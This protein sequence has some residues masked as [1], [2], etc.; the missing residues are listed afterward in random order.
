MIM[1][2]GKSERDAKVA[3][4]KLKNFL[5]HGHELKASDKE[6]L[7]KIC[8]ALLR[9]QD[10]Y[11]KNEKGRKEEANFQRKIAEHFQVYLLKK[12]GYTNQQIIDLVPIVGEERNISRMISRLR[13]RLDIKEEKGEHWYRMCEGYLQRYYHELIM[14]GGLKPDDFERIESFLERNIERT[15]YSEGRTMFL[16]DRKTFAE[17]FGLSEEEEKLR[18]LESLKFGRDFALSESKT[19]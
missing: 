12:S 13:A 9:D 16:I 10:I 4:T 5:E 8:N 18:F 11:S 7:I 19:T 3:I 15:S 2:K 14:A 1:E 6:A 17:K